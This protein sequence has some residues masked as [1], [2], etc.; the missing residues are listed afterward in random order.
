MSTLKL[1][2]VEEGVFSDLCDNEPTLAK[3][4]TR[5][6]TVQACQ[7]QEDMFSEISNRT[8]FAFSIVVFFLGPMLDKQ[9]MFFVRILGSMAFL[10]CFFLLYF[11]PTFPF[12]L[13]PAWVALSGGK[14]ISLTQP[15]IS[16]NVLHRHNHS[17][18][19]AASTGQTFTE[20]F[21]DSYHVGQ[22]NL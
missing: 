3:R 17:T 2:F 6:Q 15:K 14:I 21:S 16:T 12:L 8:I 7:E 11:V 10:L 4:D 18:D 5:N 9:G 1:I 20:I 22:W 19:N 13:K